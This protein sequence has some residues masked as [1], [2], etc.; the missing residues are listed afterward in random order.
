MPAAVAFWS[1]QGFLVWTV[2][3]CFVLFHFVFLFSLF[4]VF[5]PQPSGCWDY[6]Y[7]SAHP[8]EFPFLWP[9]FRHSCSCWIWYPRGCR[10][11]VW[12]S[13]AHTEG[14][15][16]RGRWGCMI[17]A[18]ELGAVAQPSPLGCWAKACLASVEISLSEYSSSSRLSTR[19][20]TVSRGM[21]KRWVAILPVFG[22]KKRKLAWKGEPL[23]ATPV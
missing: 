20:N 3:G 21:Q 5:L 1:S 15:H 4:S 8:G 16:N 2:W 6:R 9:G 10:D 14:V 17:K 7:A 12:R 23:V 18:S 11:S 19:A 13:M 22:A